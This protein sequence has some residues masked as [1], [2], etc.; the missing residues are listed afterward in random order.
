MKYNNMINGYKIPRTGEIK[1]TG[2]LGVLPGK[3]NGTAVE[4]KGKG[5]AGKRGVKRVST[6]CD[7]CTAKKQKTMVI[8]YKHTVNL[9]KFV[10]TVWLHYQTSASCNNQRPITEAKNA[11]FK[12]QIEGTLQQKPCAFIGSF[13][14]KILLI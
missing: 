8:L 6:D 1:H 10:F 13:R 9:T 14:H 3:E 2:N 12:C 7:L 4:V 11:W 5:H